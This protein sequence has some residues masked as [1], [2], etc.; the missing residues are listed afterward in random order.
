MN[1]VEVSTTDEDRARAVLGAMRQIEKA[2]GYTRGDRYTAQ[3]AMHRAQMRPLDP[4]LYALL[5]FFEQYPIPGKV[6]VAS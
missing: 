4:K 2:L 1:N 5:W 3:D 6:F